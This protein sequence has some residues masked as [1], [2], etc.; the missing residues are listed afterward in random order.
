MAQGIVNNGY[1]IHDER[2]YTESEID[3]KV[4]ELNSSISSEVSA[5]Q[6]ADTEL[7]N[8]I[9]LLT[10]YVTP[11][12][13]GA[14]GD[15]VTDDSNAIQSAVNS[16]KTVI[17]GRNKTYKITDTILLPN[18]ANIVGDNTTIISNAAIAFYHTAGVGNPI[19]SIS[20]K[21]ITLICDNDGI[22]IN[23]TSKNVVDTSD[24]QQGY[25]LKSF[26]ENI[27][28]RGKNNGTA[29]CCTK[30]FDSTIRNCRIELFDIGVHL[31]GC[32]INRVHDCRF[33]R[34]NTHIK[35]IMIGSFG[36]QNLID[37]NDIISVNSNGV[38]I[39]TSDRYGIIK[40]NH[41]ESASGNTNI[42]GILIKGGYSQ[43]I[44]DNR[45]DFMPGT[46]QYAI[47]VDTNLQSLVI[48]N[49][50]TSNASGAASLI[51]TDNAKKCIVSNFFKYISIKNLYGENFTLAGT[52]S[53]MLPIKMNVTPSCFPYIGSQGSNEDMLLFSYEQNSFEI[54]GGNT[55]NFVCISPNSYDTLSIVAK[56]E[57]ESTLGVL[58]VYDN[59]E[60]KAW[61]DYTVTTDWTSIPIITSKH[62]IKEVYMYA[63]NDSKIYIKG[64]TS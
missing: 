60:V 64:L 62:T 11:E 20:L 58:V 26:F 30:M 33:D 25:V 10:T 50:R 1:H 19:T 61:S 35:N 34:N 59:S 27:C 45:F 49:C 32:D 41:F 5:R 52:K 42:G 48:E 3:T 18:N 7:Q 51:F 24:S 44:K 38:F 28:F 31:Y 29:I 4:S 43:V 56:A 57:I 21:N 22:R 63:K 37:H 16:G 46:M 9:N 13:F 14:V 39:E 53:E 40:N 6:V 8:K 55:S 54:N 36:S 12:M 23:D 15:G 47:K 2:Y 17:L